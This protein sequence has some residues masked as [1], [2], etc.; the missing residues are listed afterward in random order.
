M[1]SDGPIAFSA[2]HFLPMLLSIQSLVPIISSGGTA[3]IHGWAHCIFCLCCSRFNRLGP[4]FLQEE[5]PIYTDGPIAFSAA[6]V[7]LIA[8]A[9]YFFKMCCQY[10]WMSP[11]H[12]FLLLQTCSDGP[13]AFSAAV[14]D[15]IVW[16]HYFFRKCCR[17][18]RMGPLFL[19]EE[20][21]IYV[22][23]PIA[24]SAAAVDLLA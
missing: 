10:P 14:V 20:L 1:C 5:L 13:I 9:N 3:D 23:E 19:H 8:S 18:A 7:D 11:L 12:S 15:L 22:D 17:H 4:L 6:N 2:Y 16:A 21:P 24:F